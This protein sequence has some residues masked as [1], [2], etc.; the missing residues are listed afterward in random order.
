MNYPTL[1]LLNLIAAFPSKAEEMIPKEIKPLMN[2][3]SPLS[4]SAEMV[5]D[6]APETKKLNECNF[7]E[8]KQSE[9]A[10]ILQEVFKPK[11]SEWSFSVMTTMTVPPDAFNKEYMQSTSLELKGELNQII[12]SNYSSHQNRLKAISQMCQGKSELDRIQLASYLGS[13]LA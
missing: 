5:A 9:P 2:F 10:R 1:L 8:K 12:K 6:T 7:C 3:M 4:G 11:K 13:Q